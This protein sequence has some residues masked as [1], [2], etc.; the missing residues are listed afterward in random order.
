MNKGI[1]LPCAYVLTLTFPPAKTINLKD[2]CDED[3][4]S[5]NFMSR[6]YDPQEV[7]DRLSKRKK[8]SGAK[9]GKKKESGRR[10]KDLASFAQLKRKLIA[11][12]GDDF[13]DVLGITE[14][15]NI[16]RFSA[17]IMDNTEISEKD[18]KIILS[19]V[20]ERGQEGDFKR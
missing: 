17:A 7:L 6:I 9:S 3:L 5:V 15:D 13:T 4:S 2:I 10:I 19:L 12:F 20:S 11:V 14:N 1:V 8:E 18:K 16:D